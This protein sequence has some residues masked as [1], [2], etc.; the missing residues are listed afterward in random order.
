MFTILQNIL[1]GISLAAPIGPSNLAVIK[2]GLQHGFFPAFLVGLGVS[3]VDTLYLIVIYL[4]LARFITIP[5]VRILIWT[6][7]ALVLIYLGYSGV[8]EFKGV[9]LQGKSKRGNSFMIGFMINI[10]N[11]MTIVWWLGVFGAILSSSIVN[12][13]KTVALLQSLTIILGV[14]MWHTFVAV[15]LHWGKR[16]V[17][18]TSM[19][20]VALLFGIILIGFGFYFGYNA[21]RSLLTF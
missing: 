5:S 17:N 18:E 2:R 7:G 8:L 21:I 6:F 1:L 3:V 10:S 19:R 15:L 16:F 4:G 13:S 12:V 20:Y 11:P 14:L 9:K